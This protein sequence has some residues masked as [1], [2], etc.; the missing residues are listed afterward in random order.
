MCR[1][2]CRC[3]RRRRQPLH[4]PPRFYIHQWKRY[5]LTLVIR[6]IWSK[7]GANWQERFEVKW[8][9]LPRVIAR[10]IEDEMRCAQL[11]DRH[12]EV[13]R[14]VVFTSAKASTPPRSRR[15]Q[16]SQSATD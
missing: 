3:C 9:M 5:Y 4:R 7:F 13:T 15:I 10:S 2:L 1:L 16:V 8:A 6:R 11:V 14:T 12:V